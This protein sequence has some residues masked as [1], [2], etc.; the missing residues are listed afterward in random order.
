MARSAGLGLAR[1][2]LAAPRRRIDIALPDQ[3][4]I[5]ELLPALLRHAGEELA[6]AGQEHGGWVLRRVDGS[7]LDAARTLGVQEIR[8]GDVLY[9][10]PRR[11]EWPD[12]EYD[13]VVD[14]IAGRAR[15]E[16]RSW[17]GA[18]TRRA[19]L[20][21][22][23]AAVGVAVVLL[24]SAGPPWLLPGSVLLGL[25]AVFAGVGI[26]LARALG[27]SGAGV[28][29]GIVA[30]VAAF[31][32]GLVVA[33]G[34][35]P[36]LSAEPPQFLAAFAALFVVG[37]AGYVGVGDRTQHFVAGMTAAAV[38]T[39]ATL[40]GLTGLLD[41]AD[42]AAIAVALVVALTPG[43]PLLAIRLGKLPTPVLPTTA[44]DLLADPPMPP[45]P[46]VASTVRRTDE[47]LSGMLAGG[48]AVA[49]VAQG[50]LVADAT[51]SAVVLVVLVTLA[52]LLRGRLFPAVRHRVPLMAT[53]AA[54][55]AALALGVLLLAPGTRI[56][57]AVP[58]L[59][60]LALA[61]LGAGLYFQRRQPSPYLGRIAD[62]LD[63]LVV[64][65]VV[66]TACVVLGLFTYL[67]GIY[68]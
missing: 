19:G 2:T 63:V 17:G 1:I 13:D 54:G 47:L 16:S 33:R 43:M 14:A 51:R 10:V 58:A 7:Q 12:M 65:A 11:T 60:V 36:L 30:M 55:A 8:D 49:I 42:Q 24:L 26:L 61:A 57:I 9:L 44:E 22:A 39:A 29:L 34:E 46:R 35:Q 18:A 5:A 21:L 27:D 66:P 38:G 15:A 68:G 59:V 25:A 20:A 64:L 45:P 3:A 6:D 52:M 23:A 67:R 53:G 37:L 32:G 4:P 28:V 31:L 50:V 41:A 48:A 56:G 62:I 40:F